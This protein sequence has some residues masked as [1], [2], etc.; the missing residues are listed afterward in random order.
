M[1]QASKQFLEQFDSLPLKLRI[2]SRYARDVAAGPR[3]ARHETGTDRG[4]RRAMT[5][6]IVLVASFAAWTAGV[7]IATMMSTFNRTSSA[8]SALAR[9][10]RPLAALHSTRAF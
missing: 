5:M 2:E 7:K 10:V 4:T 9:P 1:S 3:Q 6:G 8:A